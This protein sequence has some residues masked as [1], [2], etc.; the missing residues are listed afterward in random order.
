MYQYRKVVTVACRYTIGRFLD[1][2]LYVPVLRP[3]PCAIGSE[4]SFML[5]I[6]RRRR[7]VPLL[8]FACYLRYWH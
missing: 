2:R 6:D 3:S 7:R 5:C 8:P 1:F 4:R